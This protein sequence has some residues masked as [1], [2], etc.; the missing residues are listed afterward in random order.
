MGRLKPFADVPSRLGAGMHACVTLA[1][2]AMAL[3]ASSDSTT[4]FRLAGGIILSLASIALMGYAYW[5]FNWRA[6]RIAARSG[7]RADD[8][9][10]PALLAGVLFAAMIAAAFCTLPHVL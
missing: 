7:Q 4:P 6:S 1:S 3:T 10:G 2:V 5:T 9:I 8:P